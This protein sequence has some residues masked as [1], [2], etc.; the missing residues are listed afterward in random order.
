ME[1]F[2]RGEGVGEGRHKK[3]FTLKKN[4]I[5]IDQGYSPTPRTPQFEKQRIL[6]WKYMVISVAVY[7]FSNKDYFEYIF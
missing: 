2:G 7:D 5:F 1:I 4:R 6:E 3:I